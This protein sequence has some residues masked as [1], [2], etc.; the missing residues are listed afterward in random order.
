M[1]KDTADIRMRDSKT[2]F[3]YVTLLKTNTVLGASEND[4]ASYL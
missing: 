3:D 4:V 1:A 2:L